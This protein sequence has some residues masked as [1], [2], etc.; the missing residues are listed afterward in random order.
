MKMTSKKKPTNHLASFTDHLNEQ[1]GP[2]GT[3]AREE[4]EESFE[5]FRLNAVEQ[6]LKDKPDNL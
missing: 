4:F 3:P 5:K 6:N 2:P 1:Y